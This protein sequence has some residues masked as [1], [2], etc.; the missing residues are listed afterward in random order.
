MRARRSDRMDS[1][2]RSCGGAPLTRT[3]DS[4]IVIHVRRKRCAPPGVGGGRGAEEGAGS[5]GPHC[6][7]SRLSSSH[8][9]SVSDGTPACHPVPDGRTDR[10]DLLPGVPTGRLA[11]FFT[12]P[13]RQPTGKRDT[14]NSEHLKDL[15]RRQDSDRKPNKA[16]MQR[17]LEV[18]KG[19][20]S[21]Q[22]GPA[23]KHCALACV[24]WTRIS[25]EE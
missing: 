20:G 18:G 8:R 5:R 12:Q 9:V 19:C 14:M 3:C 25:Q 2:C 15:Q 24:P 6:S 13:R 23:R 22:N 17:S 11:F 10:D 7:S 1:E 4:S 16:S 21:W